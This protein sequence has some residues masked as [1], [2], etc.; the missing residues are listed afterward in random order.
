MSKITIKPLGC[1]VFLIW[2]S[3]GILGWYHV[4]IDKNITQPLLL[5]LL[6]VFTTLAYL[7]LKERK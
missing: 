7:L 3:L 1:T 2:Y 6:W 5:T 4:F